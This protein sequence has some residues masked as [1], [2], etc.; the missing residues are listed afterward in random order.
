MSCARSL[1]V[2]TLDITKQQAGAAMGKC[3]LSDLADGVMI[4]SKEKL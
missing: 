1:V 2:D 4:S 3:S